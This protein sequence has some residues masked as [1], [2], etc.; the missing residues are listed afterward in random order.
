MKRTILDLIESAE[1]FA[2]AQE[3]MAVRSQ[4]DSQ[5]WH[6]IALAELLRD[7]ASALTPAER[8]G[9]T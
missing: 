2:L 4:E 1:R 7:M 6:H 8:G 9:A 3:D 5:H